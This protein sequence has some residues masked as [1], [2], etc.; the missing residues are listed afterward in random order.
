MRKALKALRDAGGRL[1]FPEYSAIA[2]EPTTKAALVRHGA[3]EVLPPWSTRRRL[4]QRVA[5]VI[6]TRKGLSALRA[7]ER[8]GA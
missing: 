8:L 1:P 7:V 4:P 6:I 3:V 2:T 5:E